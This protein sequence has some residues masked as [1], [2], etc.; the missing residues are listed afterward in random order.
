MGGHEL[1][2]CPSGFTGGWDEA[3]PVLS[4]PSSP[5]P[6]CQGLIY[7]LVLKLII[8]VIY[9]AIKE[10]SHV[11]DYTANKPWQIIAILKVDPISHS[12]HGGEPQSDGSFASCCDRCSLSHSL[13]APA[14]VVM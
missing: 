7:R 4:E 14:E 9:K 2:P 5:V 12:D 13:S 1:T 10:R 6:I 8:L 3:V 11:S